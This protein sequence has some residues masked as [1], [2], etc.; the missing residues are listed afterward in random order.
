MLHQRTKI[1]NEVEMGNASRLR[2][3]ADGPKNIV[4]KYRGRGLLCD[5][6][7]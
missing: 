3:N 7:L 6:S 1:G 5:R 2:K 4:R